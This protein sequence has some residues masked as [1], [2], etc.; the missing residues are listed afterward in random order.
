MTYNVNPTINNLIVPRIGTAVFRPYSELGEGNVYSSP[1]RVSLTWDDFK[2]PDNNKAA[3]IYNT[4]LRNFMF[5]Y[6]KGVDV[7]TETFKNI[8]LQSDDISKVFSFVHNNKYNSFSFSACLID[9]SYFLKDLDEVSCSSRIM[10]NVFYAIINQP[11]YGNVTNYM[12]NVI[13]FK[14]YLCRPPKI[15]ENT[16]IDLSAQKITIFFNKDIQIS[17]KNNIFVTFLNKTVFIPDFTIDSNNRTFIVDISKFN[18]YNHGYFTLLIKK[19]VV[20]NYFFHTISSFRRR[21]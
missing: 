9:Y 4:D 13:D 15:S 20:K 2:N 7:N 21:L 16:S 10:D 3:G 14:F 18:K 12:D 1:P 6:M 19:D 11:S 8:W 17:N 5:K